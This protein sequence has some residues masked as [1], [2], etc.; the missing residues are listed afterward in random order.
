M[1]LSAA[2]IRTPASRRA[3]AWWTRRSRRTESVPAPRPRTSGRPGHGRGR[4]RRTIG[5]GLLKRR[6]SRG[7]R[8]ASTERPK[9]IRYRE[10]PLGKSRMI[11]RD[12]TTALRR[13]GLGARPGEMPP[14][15]AD[16][17][18]FVLSALADPGAALIE[19]ASLDPSHVTFVAALDARQRQRAARKAVELS[20]VRPMRVRRRLPRLPWRPLPPRRSEPRPSQRRAG[21]G[22]PLSRGRPRRASRAASPP[23]RP[24]SSAW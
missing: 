18:G 23:R 9:A 10:W 7:A 15:A 22:A 4:R 6:S 2:A 21:S 17:R 11:T 24:F 13:F 1:L 12:T 14:I 3:L 16:P 5:I 20:S 19:D 8:M